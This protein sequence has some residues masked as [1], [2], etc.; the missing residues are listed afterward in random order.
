MRLV[1]LSDGCYVNPEDVQELKINDYADVLTVHMRSGV[2]HSVARDYNKTIYDTLRRVKA[3]LE[4][5]PDEK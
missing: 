3:E 4:G 1:R 2:G 5:P